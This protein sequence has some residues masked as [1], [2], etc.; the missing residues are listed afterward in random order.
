MPTFKLNAPRLG[1]RATAVLKNG[2]F[3]VHK[4]SQA[5]LE[6]KGDPKDSYAQLHENLLKQGKLRREGKHLVFTED[7][8]FDT[9]RGRYGSNAASVVLGRQANGRIAW[10][11]DEDEGP[12]NDEP[13]ED[14]WTFA[15]EKHLEEFL[16][17]N[18]ASTELGRC[19][20]IFEGED[21][22][23][24]Q[25]YPTDTGVIDV[26]AISKDRKEFLVVELKKGR[27]SDAVVGQVM[28]YMG[29]VQVEL[30]NQDQRVRGVIIALDRDRR[31][32]RALRFTE[33]VDF[34]RYKVCFSLFQD[35]A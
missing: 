5:Q 3:V 14:L 17:N 26:L 33:A 29:S 18:W 10:V 22:T 11:K 4:G 9:S 25:Q 32:E 23:R 2:D 16:V 28:R 20:D 13:D 27:A 7:C 21:G 12:P 30:A 24:G 35:P 8:P 19:Y 15:L 34:Y 6:W 1:I 31:L